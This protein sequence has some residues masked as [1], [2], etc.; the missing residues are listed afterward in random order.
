MAVGKIV[1]NNLSKYFVLSIQ[2]YY[3]NEKNDFQFQDSKHENRLFQLWDGEEFCL[4]RSALGV[5][6]KWLL[7]I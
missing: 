4:A 7:N 6:G 5:K 1:L 3:W 2:L